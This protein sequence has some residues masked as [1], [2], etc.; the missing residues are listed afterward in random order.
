MGLITWHRKRRLAALEKLIP[1]K[2]KQ[3][4]AV[5][6]KKD[7]LLDLRK[8]LTKLEREKASLLNK[9]GIDEDEEDLEEGLD[10]ED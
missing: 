7:E 9:L 5:R 1:L 10:D 8:E 4:Q 6:G 2:N 3:L